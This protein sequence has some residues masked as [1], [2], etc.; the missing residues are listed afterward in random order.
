MIAR[1]ISRRFTQF[2]APQSE[3][4]KPVRVAVT[5]ACGNIGYA[6]LFR[7]ANGAMLGPNQPVI[8]HLVDLPHAENALKGVRM[9]LDDCAF[10]LLQEIVTT[11]DQSVGFKDIDFALLV[12]SKPRGPGMERADLLKD[13][14][15][16]F[17]K[18]G[19]SLNDYASRN[20]RVLVVGNPA[21]TNCMIAQ[22]YAKDLPSD[23]FHAMTR[24][25]H[26]RAVSQLAT[27]LKVPSTS[28]EKLCIWGN[29]S[30]TMYPDIRNTTVNGKSIYS[31]IDKNW[32][33]N[34][35]IPGVQQRGAAIIK[36]RGQSS[37]ASAGNAAISH[38]R[39]WVT[40]TNGQW[41]SFSVKSK[42]EYGVPEGL[43]FSY[44]V[45]VTNGKWSIVK[46]LEITPEAQA[47]IDT[48]TKELVSEREAVAHLLK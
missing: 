20:V 44:P 32:L 40:G 25:D 19:Q 7:I 12:G 15:A 29:H 48:T 33:N 27:H 21:N 45:T 11:T 30:P 36:A 8:L 10:P 18:T 14:G 31:T 2:V 17:V 47:R 39:D 34:D 46:G 43:I 37:A 5:G 4:K 41:A 35:F 3:W 16:I 1:S 26:D 38:M 22:H 13:N 6:T 42:G 23:N 24:L 9:E 28:I